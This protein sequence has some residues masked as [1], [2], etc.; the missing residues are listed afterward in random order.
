MRDARESIL[1]S[2]YTSID[3]LEAFKVLA[4]QMDK[5]PCLRVTVLLNIIRARFKSTYDSNV[6]VG[7]KVR[8]SPLERRLARHG[9]PGSLL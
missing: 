2:G 5:R 4:S 9:T 3:G 1:I 6:A 8:G 7:G